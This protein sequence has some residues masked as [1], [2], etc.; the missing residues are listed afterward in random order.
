MITTTAIPH[1]EEKYLI[2]IPEVDHQHQ[3]FLQLVH[4]FNNRCNLRMEHNLLS[5]HL[6]EII[7]Y[8]QFHFFSEENLMLLYGY[9]GYKQ[10]HEMHDEI[11]DRLATKAN[12]YNFNEHSLEELVDFMVE[13]FLYHT[14]EEDSKISNYLNQK[15][16]KL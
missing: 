13:W 16:I 14:I 4:R 12:L 7:K 15:N 6:N 2:Q 10:H 11:I 9:P 1:W 3:Y 8:A 5:R